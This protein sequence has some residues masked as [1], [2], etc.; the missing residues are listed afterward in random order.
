MVERAAPSFVLQGDCLDLAARLRRHPAWD[1]RPVD[2]AYLDPPF[3]T[4][5]HFGARIGE[6]KRRARVA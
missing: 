2:V 6:G 5:G 3:N 4:G 1:E